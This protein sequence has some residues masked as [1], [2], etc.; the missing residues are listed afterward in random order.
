MSAATKSLSRLSAMLSLVC[1]AT[2]L[3]AA[4]LTLTWRGNDDDV[5]AGYLVELHDASGALLRTVDAQDKTRLVL[6]NLDDN[7]LLFVAVRPY[8]VGGN[9]ARKAS[10]PLV[11]YP[12]PRID[13]LDGTIDTGRPFKLTLYG[14]NFAD[15]ARVVSKRRGVTV[16]STTVLRTDAAIVDVSVRSALTQPLSAAD[17]TVAN[18]VRRAAEYLEAHPELL[19][20]DGSGAVDAA[21]LARVDAAFGTRPGGAGLDAELDLNADGVVDGED[22]APVRRFLN[23]VERG[24]LEEQGSP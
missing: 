15:G 23:R 8:D 14:A 16:T 11:T 22:A 12:N 5:T 18:P 9:R 21:D 4:D 10:D 13:R 19:D 24:S 1:L 2:P 6:R 3:W 20:V 7:R 17:F